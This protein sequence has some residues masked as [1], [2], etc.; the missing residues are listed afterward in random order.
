ML[1]FASLAARARRVA[2]RNAGGMLA[3]LLRER[4]WNFITLEDE[5]RARRW[6][7]GPNRETSRPRSPSG[8]KTPMPVAAVVRSVLSDHM[9]FEQPA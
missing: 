6:L 2:T 1:R 4:C 9:H 8:R 7:A 5:D 3:W